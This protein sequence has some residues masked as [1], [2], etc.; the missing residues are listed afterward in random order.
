MRFTGLPICGR[1]VCR[2][3]V[4]RSNVVRALSQSCLDVMSLVLSAVTAEN[5]AMSVRCLFMYAG[6]EPSEFHLRYPIRDMPAVR[7][8]ACAGMVFPVKASSF[9]A[10]RLV[11]GAT[12]V[13]EMCNTWWV[14]CVTTCIACITSRKIRVSRSLVLLVLSSVLHRILFVR[15]VPIAG[16]HVDE[17][18]LTS[19]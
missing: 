7:I 2:R 19:T 3:E 14:T 12:I 15:S 18:V 8:I 4:S 1:T 13:L 16:G 5:A 6:P 17:L 10:V 11:P 9:S